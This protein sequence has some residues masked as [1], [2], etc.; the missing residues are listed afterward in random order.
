MIPK[1][2]LFDIYARKR[3]NESDKLDLSYLAI[4]SEPLFFIQRKSSKKHCKEARK[5]QNIYINGSYPNLNV[6]MFIFL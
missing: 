6:N 2:L 4:F 3:V 5:A 1:G